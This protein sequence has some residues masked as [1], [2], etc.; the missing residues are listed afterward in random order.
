MRSSIESKVKYNVNSSTI[1]REL[2][3]KEGVKKSSGKPKQFDII[4]DKPSKFIIN[5][6]RFFDIDAN[7]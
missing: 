1:L 6:N 3:G 4:T 7:K 5:L 2:R